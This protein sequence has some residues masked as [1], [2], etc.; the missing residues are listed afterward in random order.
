MPL[1]PLFE[2]SHSLF[3]FLFGF[4]DDAEFGI[5]FH[6]LDVDF[7]VDFMS[8]D[9]FDFAS[10]RS[11]SFE[12]DNFSCEFSVERMLWLRGCIPQKKH[13]TNCT[14]HFENIKKSC[15][16]RHFTCHRL[17]QELMHKL[18]SSDCFGN[19]CH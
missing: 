19:F 5:S 3:N 6:F 8:K 17:T 4:Q 18:S 13:Q 10:I 2:D 1:P 15:W 7:G 9:T 16:Y 14:Y 12:Y 11:G